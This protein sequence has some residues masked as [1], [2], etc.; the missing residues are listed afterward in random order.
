M[1]ALTPREI[2]EF[3]Y[4]EHSP[5]ATMSMEQ[6][7]DHIEKLIKDC[8]VDYHN[9][10]VTQPYNIEEW[11]EW[12]KNNNKIVVLPNELTKGPA[13]SDPWPVSYCVRKEP[14]ASD[15]LPVKYPGTCE[16]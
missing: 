5:L 4:A 12:A 14:L 9:E 16:A 1:S 2:A 6:T 8:C 7:I 15:L 11:I 13:Q 10:K 3:V